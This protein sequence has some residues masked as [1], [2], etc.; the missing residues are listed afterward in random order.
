YYG[1]EYDALICTRFLVAEFDCQNLD[2]TTASRSLGEFIGYTLCRT[3]LER[4]VTFAALF[5]L[6][7][8]KS[9]HPWAICSAGEKLFLVSFMVANKILIDCSYWSKSFARI[10]RYST[11]LLDI[12]EGEKELCDLLEWRLTVC[13]EELEAFTELLERR[14]M[15]AS[16]AHTS[17]NVCHI[18]TVHPE[19]LT[20]TQNHVIDESLR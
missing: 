9:K 1:Y 8:V 11:T 2:P 5:L 19:R 14:Y 3:R 6:Q 12:N 13:P 18:V 15:I 16:S 7:R 17:T 10:G 4:C 20:R